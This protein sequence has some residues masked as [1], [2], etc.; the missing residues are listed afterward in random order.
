MC[1]APEIRSI[2][3][4]LMPIKRNGSFATKRIKK[5]GSEAE[6]YSHSL[7]RTHATD[8]V[9]ERAMLAPQ[10]AWA[11]APWEMMLKHSVQHR[12]SFHLF[13]GCP[14]LRWDHIQRPKWNV[15]WLQL[16]GITLTLCAAEAVGQLSSVLRHYSR[17]LAR[18]TLVADHG[19]IGQNSSAPVSRHS[20]SG[21]RFLPTF[22][23]FIASLFGTKGPRRFSDSPRDQDGS[24]NYAKL[25]QSA[26]KD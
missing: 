21:I 15:Y 16:L 10:Y 5:N 20:F 25:I 2:L 6:R 23:V 9:I 3:A 11:S 24:F 13:R 8:S 14:I 22:S 1:G 17:N 19:L 4:R 12:D 26:S 18:S 7:D